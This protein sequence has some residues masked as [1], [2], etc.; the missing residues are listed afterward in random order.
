MG[1]VQKKFIVAGGPGA[2]NAVMGSTKMGV[3]VQQQM[4]NSQ[5]NNNDHHGQNY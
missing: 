4:L 2:Q 1:G 5:N 3:S